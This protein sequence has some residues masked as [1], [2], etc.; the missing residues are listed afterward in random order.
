MKQPNGNGI[1]PMSHSLLKH[2]VA[3]PAYKQR[4]YD[5]HHRLKLVKF[6]LPKMK[7]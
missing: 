6:I 7:S 4:F 3:I 2:G 5:R 1:R